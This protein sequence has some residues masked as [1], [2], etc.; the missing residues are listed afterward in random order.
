M[1]RNKESP[2]K[3]V[4]PLKRLSL[5]KK[6]STITPANS[7]S[8]IHGA[9]GSEGARASTT[10]SARSSEGGINNTAAGSS[11]GGIKSTGAISSEGAQ[12]TAYSSPNR[13]ENA[14]CPGSSAETQ[15]R[16]CQ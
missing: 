7:L 3:L 16:P 1:V 6:G 11:E 10:N 9:R 12:R 5:I 13:D 4:V 15:P 8:I 14:G 2:D